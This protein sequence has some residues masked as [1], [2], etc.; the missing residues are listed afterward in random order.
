MTSKD[1][2]PT[3]WSS[4]VTTSMLLGAY[5]LHVALSS[6]EEAVRNVTEAARERDVPIVI[7]SQTARGAVDLGRYEPGSSAR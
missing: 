2:R 3:S 4:S 1:T 7:V 6:L 5:L